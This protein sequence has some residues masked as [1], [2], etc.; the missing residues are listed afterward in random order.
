MNTS[1]LLQVA[2][3]HVH[4][5]KKL[6]FAGPTLLIVTLMISSTITTVTIL[7]LFLLFLLLL[8]ILLLYY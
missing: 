3:S 6:S 1:R 4:G 8:L 5:L 2:V 7:F